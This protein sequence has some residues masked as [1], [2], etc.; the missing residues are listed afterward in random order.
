M[1]VDWRDGSVRKVVDGGG[2]FDV[3]DEDAADQSVD[4]EYIVWV[5]RNDYDVT[6][7]DINS[8][9]IESLFSSSE[10]LTS[11]EVRSCGNGVL[12]RGF[13]ANSILTR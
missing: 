1:G 3:I 7:Y 5:G 4:D 9:K 12:W 2:V 11:S 6:V 8:G 13:V 10:V